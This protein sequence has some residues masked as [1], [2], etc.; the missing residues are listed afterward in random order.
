M[1]LE[2]K[3]QILTPENLPPGENSSETSDD[4]HAGP[5]DHG[6]DVE[7]NGNHDRP[8]DHQRADELPPSVVVHPGNGQCA[9]GHTDCRS[10]Q[11]GQTSLFFTGFPVLIMFRSFRN[12]EDPDNA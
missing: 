2:L 12:D 9:H 6:Q 10:E 1:A 5:A 4:P 8:D 7:N 3:R 11:I